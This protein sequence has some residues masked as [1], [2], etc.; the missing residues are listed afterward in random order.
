MDKQL[1]LLFNEHL[2]K[3]FKKSLEIYCDE[4]SKKNGIPLDNKFENVKYKRIF[5]EKARNILKFLK[6]NE[7][8]KNKIINNKITFDKLL[9]TE[10]YKLK[11]K[12]WKKFIEHEKEIMKSIK[13]ANIQATTDQFLC[14]KCKK[15]ECVYTSRQTRSADEPMTNFVTCVNCGHKWRC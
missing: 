12:L 15:R 14:S 10:Y 3:D 7:T 6:K 1:N 4:Y 5:N 11:P 2:Q 9:N 13:D 8:W